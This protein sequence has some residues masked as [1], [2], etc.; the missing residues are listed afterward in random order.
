MIRNKSLRTQ[1]QPTNLSC[2][3]G[4]ISDDVGV[5]LYSPDLED[6]RLF[7]DNIKK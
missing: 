7:W 2:S 3:A 4:M 1:T 5:G 6:Y